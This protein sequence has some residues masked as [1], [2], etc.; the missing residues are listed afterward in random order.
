MYNGGNPPSGG[1]KLTQQ[2]CDLA[3]PLPIVYVTTMRVRVRVGVRVP[4]PNPN[5]TPSPPL[6]CVCCF[7]ALHTYRAHGL[8]A[9]TMQRIGPSVPLLKHK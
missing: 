2:L 7:T 9:Y 3:N 5:P 1:P 6:C 4:K 8:V